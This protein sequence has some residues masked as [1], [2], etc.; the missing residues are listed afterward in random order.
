MKRFII[1]LLIAVMMCFV[2]TGCDGTRQVFDTTIKFDEAIIALPDGTVVRGQV[3]SWLDFDDSDQI[4]VKIDGTTY[5]VFS[6]NVA[7][8]HN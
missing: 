1:S 7:L 6:S 4:Q 3:E 5:L 8:I 2:I